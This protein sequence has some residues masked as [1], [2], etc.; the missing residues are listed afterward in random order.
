MEIAVK[1]L[2]DGLK[3]SPGNK[4]L[5]ERL[6]EYSAKLKEEEKERTKRIEEE[7]KKKYPSTETADSRPIVMNLDPERFQR[8]YCTIDAPY[9]E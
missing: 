8:V 9:D 4:E 3:I 1:A 6:K 7:L 2:Q 5:N